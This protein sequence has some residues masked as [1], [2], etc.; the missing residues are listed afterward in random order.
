MRKVKGLIAM[1]LVAGMVG[2]TACGGLL[3]KEE[4]LNEN[5]ETPVV[6][7]NEKETEVTTTIEE[8]TEATEATEVATGYEDV[9]DALVECGL[10]GDGKLYNIYY[11]MI[12]DETTE[13][14]RKFNA[15]IQGSA[16]FCGLSLIEEGPY[17]GVEYYGS[18]CDGEDETGTSYTATY[19]NITIRVTMGDL[20]TEEIRDEILSKMSGYEE[21]L[22]WNE[23]DSTI[24]DKN[25]SA[26]VPMD[27]YGARFGYD[28]YCYMNPVSN[29]FLQICCV[30]DGV[31]AV[32][33]SPFMK[34][35][36]QTTE[37]STKVETGRSYGYEGEALL[38]WLQYHSFQY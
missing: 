14:E 7:V 15:G 6:K 30:E 25:W 1:G 2:L 20:S 13:L 5:K 17:D 16:K 37:L 24:I 32:S 8:M 33:M 36:A 19:M 11:D 18:S 3:D 21:L 9:Y 4:T 38:Q 27:G 28:G 22:G 12:G 26:Y 31:V 10:T 34:S 23:M 29:T 35:E